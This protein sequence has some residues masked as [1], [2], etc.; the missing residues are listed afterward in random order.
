MYSAETIQEITQQQQVKKKSRQ[1]FSKVEDE[2]LIS[3]YNEYPDEWILI[4]DRMNRKVRQVRERYQT[5][6]QPNLKV[7]S[8]TEE[9]EK[10]LEKKVKEYG[11]NWVKISAFFDNRTKTNIKNH[12][13]TM[14]NRR[15]INKR[16]RSLLPSEK[17][18]EQEIKEENEE[19]RE[20]E[21]SKMNDQEIFDSYQNVQ[22]KSFPGIIPLTI[23]S[24]ENQ[25]NISH[26]EPINMNYQINMNSQINMNPQINNQNNFNFNYNFNQSSF[27]YENNYEDIYKDI[28]QDNYVLTF[29]SI[30]SSNSNSNLDENSMI[31]EW[32]MIY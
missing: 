24:T 3:L 5:F 8:W 15:F 30:S 9:E 1:R 18:N 26:L 29:N 20:I 23:P 11:T 4:A 27:D 7:S 10:L 21:N 6:L 25:S 22:M 17:E 13:S 2:Q 12:W 16:K 32:N 31:F 19:E 14:I 28:D